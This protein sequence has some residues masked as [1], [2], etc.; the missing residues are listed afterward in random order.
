MRFLNRLQQHQRAMALIPGKP[1]TV[2][3]YVG[4]CIFGFKCINSDLVEVMAIDAIHAGLQLGRHNVTDN[5]T[6]SLQQ[7]TIYNTTWF[8]DK[9]SLVKSKNRFEWNSPMQFAAFQNVTI[10]DDCIHEFFMALYELARAE[11]HQNTMDRIQKYMEAL[12]LPK[13]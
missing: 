10:S 12:S 9:T 1:S 11:M 7:Q 13:Q 8:Q 3:G 2:L 4:S 5:H 6:D